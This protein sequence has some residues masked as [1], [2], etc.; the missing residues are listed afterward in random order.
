EPAGNVTNVTAMA[1]IIAELRR[2]EQQSHSS[3]AEATEG[4]LRLSAGLRYLEPASDTTTFFVDDSAMTRVISDRA[5]APMKRVYEWAYGNVPQPV[6]PAPGDHIKPTVKLVSKL[7]AGGMGSV[8]QA[9]NLTLHTPVAVKL[10]S[11]QH[12][13]D[14]ELRQR[15]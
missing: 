4:L 1:D 11:P 7:G 13:H 14:A 8:W 15:F 5:L 6:D 10:M 3:V 9:E 2:L 12:L